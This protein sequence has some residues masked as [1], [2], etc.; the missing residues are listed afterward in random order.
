MFKCNFESCP[1][2]VR[3]LHTKDHTE[4]ECRHMR[5]C[6]FGRGTESRK[7][8]RCQNASGIMIDPPYIG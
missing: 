7:E 5:A 6:C 4:D 8:V 2:R 3:C 1:N